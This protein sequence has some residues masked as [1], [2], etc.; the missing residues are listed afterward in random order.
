MHR[1]RPM[2][3][4]VNVQTATKKTTVMR[5]SFQNVCL[6]FIRTPNAK[7]G[8]PAK[9]M[10]R[11]GNAR[12]ATP[13]NVRMM[14]TRWGMRRSVGMVNGQKPK[15]SVQISLHAQPRITVSNAS[16]NVTT[17]GRALKNALIRHANPSVKRMRNAYNDAA[18]VSL[19][20]ALVKMIPTKIV[21]KMPRALPAQKS[22][23][24]AHGKRKAARISGRYKFHV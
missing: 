10:A 6:A 5:A 3:C 15:N 18:S 14:R 16:S 4:A 2:G 19:N 21:L 17:I 24:T 11:A 7:A 22:V 23:L 9:R 8:H 1:A 13:C 20:A 12:M